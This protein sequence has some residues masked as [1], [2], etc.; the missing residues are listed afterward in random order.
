MPLATALPHV[1]KEPSHTSSYIT[2]L[3]TH[4][5]NRPILQSLLVGSSDMLAVVKD[6]SPHIYYG[7]GDGIRSSWCSY[8]SDNA[9]PASY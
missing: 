1:A 8:A 5:S 6:V 3:G 7:T 9:S 2:E 4:A